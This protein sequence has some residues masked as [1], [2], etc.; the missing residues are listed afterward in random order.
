MNIFRIIFAAVL[1]A[2]LWAGCANP[3]RKEEK[4]KEAVHKVE[5]RLADN[6]DEQKKHGR[7]FS[8]AANYALSMDPSPSDESK[9]AASMLSRSL[10]LLGDPQYE[11]MMALKEMV[12]GLLS[13]NQQL[14]IHATNML[15]RKDAEIGSLQTVNESIQSKLKA[16]LAREAKVSAENAVYAGKYITLWHTIY[17]II[18]LPIAVLLLLLL[19][20]LGTS[21]MGPPFS[22]LGK[23]PDWLAG[24]CAKVLLRVPDAAKH[25][26]TVAADMYNKV[27]LTLDHTVA[28]IEEAKDSLKQSHPGAVDVLK[29]ALFADRNDTVIQPMIAQIKADLKKV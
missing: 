28:G 4:A 1:G 26:G 2:L 3:Q 15:A 10:N 24:K 25:A 23:I 12:R 6:V 21:A 13:T 20:R 9:V 19:V 7:D 5:A 8:Y 27:K 22:Q 18:G 29:D 17:W 14:R 16:A 11:E